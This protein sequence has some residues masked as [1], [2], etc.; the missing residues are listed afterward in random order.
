MDVTRL[1]VARVLELEVPISWQEAGALVFESVAKAQELGGSDSARVEPAGCLVTRG[2]EVVL[3]DGAARAHPEAMADLAIDLLAACETPGELGAAVNAR[4]LLPFLEA[5]GQDTTW[6]R[7]RVQIAAVALRAL[8]AE[9]DRPPADRSAVRHF[10]RQAP[11]DPGGVA[12]AISARR[13]APLRPQP[14]IGASARAI[15]W[16]AVA[17]SATAAGFGLWQVRAQ[18]PRVSPVV[19]GP[20]RPSHVQPDAAALTPVAL[21]VVVEQPQTEP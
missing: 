8:A 19:T 2:G 11:R 12:V 20:A 6:K 14:A 3:V 15:I 1:S 10:T 13:P 7:R 4:Q 9:A 18:Q 16:T 5:L 17:V 21:P